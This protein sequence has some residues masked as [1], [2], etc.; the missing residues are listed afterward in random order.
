MHRFFSKQQL[1]YAI[2]VIEPTEGIIFNRGLLMNIGFVESLKDSNNYWECFAL[3]DVDAIPENERNMYSCP[4]DNPRHMAVQR[5]TRNYEL[6]YETYFGGVTL[7]TKEQ[8]KKCNGFSNL[9]FGWG[10]EG[11]VIL[12]Y[13]HKKL[14]HTEIKKH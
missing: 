1:D 7:M 14:Y 4:F 5:S 8:F 13:F 3:H 2:Y 10:M 11:K 12:F 6:K 9:Y